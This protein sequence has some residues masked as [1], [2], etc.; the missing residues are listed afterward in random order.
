VDVSSSLL[1]SV[2]AAEVRASTEVG[3]GLVESSTAAANY[4]AVR[5]PGPE[6]GVVVR[7]DDLARLIR[8]A[9]VLGRIST[10]L[11]SAAG[12]QRSLVSCVVD[13][14]TSGQLV[15]FEPGA[16]RRVGQSLHLLAVGVFVS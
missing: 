11:R 2:P 1:E 3:P 12:T 15:L 9:A 4:P 6:R 8:P 5:S 14:R 10:T 13:E 7:G 16:G